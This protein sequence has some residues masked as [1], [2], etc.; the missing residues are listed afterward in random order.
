M[1]PLR[2][3]SISLAAV[4]V[5]ALAQP[6]A[7]SAGAVADLDGELPVAAEVLQSGG[8][9]LS[10]AVEQVRRQYGGRIISAETRR[11]SNR[12][13]HHIKVLTRENKVKTVKVNGRR[14]N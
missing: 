3:M 1:T 14:L 4:L 7:A 2:N 6:C 11:R 8:P 13:V 9:S 5:T 12:E 10:E